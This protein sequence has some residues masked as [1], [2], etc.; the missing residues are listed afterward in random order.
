MVACAE[1][2]L[3]QAGQ[4]IG[5]FAKCLHFDTDHFKASIHLANLLLEHDFHEPAVSFYQ[6]AI[7]IHPQSVSAHFG[8]MLAIKSN[9]KEKDS[10]VQF[11]KETLV[12]K[13]NNV[14][15]LT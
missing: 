5:N 11:F 9:L 7:R 14:E 10:V 8:M 1:K 4:S 15:V 2:R 6:N 12:V 13:P 3:N